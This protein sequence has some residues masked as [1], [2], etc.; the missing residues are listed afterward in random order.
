MLFQDRILW[1]SRFNDLIDK[2]KKKMEKDNDN[3]DLKEYP[4]L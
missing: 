3:I 4:N 2:L 1:H